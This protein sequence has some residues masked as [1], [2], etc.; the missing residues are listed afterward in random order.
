MHQLRYLFDK[1]NG[2]VCS[3]C[4]SE[5]GWNDERHVRLHVLGLR[6]SVVKARVYDASEY[7]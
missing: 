6:V 5:W 7:M 3:E 4:G 1:L 2:N